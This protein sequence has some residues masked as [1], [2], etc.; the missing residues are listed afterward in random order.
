[1]GSLIQKFADCRAHVAE[2]NCHKSKFVTAISIQMTFPEIAFAEIVKNFDH[3]VKRTGNAFGNNQAD[4]NHNDT[5]YGNNA[6]QHHNHSA[7]CVFA[8][9]HHFVRMFQDSCLNI[10]A[11]VAYF[12]C[13]RHA[14]FFIVSH[15]R[16]SVI[17]H[18][19]SVS[20][21]I[22]R[23]SHCH[24]LRTGSFKF[25]PIFSHTVELCNKL[26]I[27]CYIFG[28]SVHCFFA[29]FH[30]CIELITARFE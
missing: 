12:D 16:I 22:F 17:C 15:C 5:D 1:M 7:D 6:N 25:V 9:L 11:L 18:C 13:I 3:F 14:F 27:V 4:K 20:T 29:L 30:G 23:R 2:C 19:H 8:F 10:A 21:C 24:Q 26:R 28:V